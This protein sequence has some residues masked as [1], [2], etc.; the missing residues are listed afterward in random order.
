MKKSVL[1]LAFALSFLVR[2]AFASNSLSLYKNS[3]VA[4][5]YAD[6]YHGRKT[7]NGEIFN[8]YDL[9]AAHKT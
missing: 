8:M 4:S 7:S 2:G 6:K 3:A 1:F 5:Y 9:T